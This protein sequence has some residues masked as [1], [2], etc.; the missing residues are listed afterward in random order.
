MSVEKPQHNLMLTIPCIAPVLVV[1]CY[2]MTY[3]L[4]KE[5]RCNTA[6]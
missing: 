1:L 2:V 3:F 4:F 5:N 6:A